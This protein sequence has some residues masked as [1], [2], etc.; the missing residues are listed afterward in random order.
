MNDYMPYLPLLNL[1]SIP[2][3]IQILMIGIRLETRLTKLEVHQERVEIYLGFK[4]MR[5]DP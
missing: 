3:M 5:A 4:E 2:I 1:L